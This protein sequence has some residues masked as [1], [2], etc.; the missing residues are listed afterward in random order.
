MNGSVHRK[1]YYLAHH[2]ATALFPA[3]LIAN[4][5]KLPPSLLPNAS[6]KSPYFR[7][8]TINPTRLNHKY[9][10]DAEDRDPKHHLRAA[11]WLVH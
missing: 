3:P 1:W 11:A 2:D 8:S 9:V 5:D 6:L 10:V 4:K 7:Q